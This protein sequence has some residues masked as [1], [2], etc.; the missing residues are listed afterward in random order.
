MLAVKRSY[1]QQQTKQMLK[2]SIDSFTYERKILEHQMMV[3]FPTNY[4]VANSSLDSLRGRTKLCFA[5]SD[6]SLEIPTILSTDI[7]AN[8]ITL[9]ILVIITIVTFSIV[10]NCLIS[11]SFSGSV[12]FNCK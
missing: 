2:E 6:L 9:V 12:F 4:V 10:F 8:F 11:P 3:H 7:C 1:K 5:A